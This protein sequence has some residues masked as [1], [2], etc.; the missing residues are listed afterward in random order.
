MVLKPCS[1][2]IFAFR[3]L[4]FFLLTCLRVSDLS[5]PLSVW[6]S[7]VDYFSEFMG[8][9]SVSNFETKVSQSHKVSNLPFYTSPAA[10]SEEK[11]MF[12]QAI[13]RAAQ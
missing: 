5:F 11:R 3:S 12:S 6:P 8:T 13:K 1:Q 4:E 7:G 9:V 10:K 2:T